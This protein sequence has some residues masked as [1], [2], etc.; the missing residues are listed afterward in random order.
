VLDVTHGDEFTTLE[1]AVRSLAGQRIGSV[2][3]HPDRSATVPEG[4]LRALDEMGLLAPR[5]T[6]DGGDGIPDHLALTMIA[7][8]LARCDAGTALDVMMGAHACALLARCGTPAQRARAGGRDRSG[9]GTVMYYEGFGRSPLELE[10]TAIPAGAGWRL[11]GRKVAVVRAQASGFAVAIARNGVGPKAFLVPAAALSSLRVDRDDQPSGKVGAR[12]SATSIVELAEVPAE[13][14][15]GGTDLDLHRGLA[16]LRLSVASI[17]VGVAAATVAYAAAYA[18]DRE[19]FG[20]TIASFQGVAFPLVDAE[21]GVEGARLAIR[22]L[23]AGLADLDDPQELA[24]ATGA[25]V[26]AASQAAS[27]AT[28]TAVNTL[29]G[30]GYLTDHPVERSYRDIAFL[31]AIDFDPFATEW[32][33]A[34]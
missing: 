6:E 17:L 31:A 23:A 5:P 20:R 7:E 12:S 14:L 34:R 15:D 22:D 32:S 9:R 33:S 10:T 29:G 3:P 4:A 25:A 8:E 30:H 18:S 24:D 26:G 11:S 21:M 2:S 16:A 1:T 28:V 19:A 13:P 27:A